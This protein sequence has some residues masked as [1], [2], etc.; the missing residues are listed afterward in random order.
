VSDLILQ[1]WSEHDWYAHR[2]A[3]DEVLAG[4]GTDPVFGSW[5][6]QTG[7]W[8]HFGRPAGWEFLLLAFECEGSIVGFLPAYS[9]WTRRR[10]LALRSVQLLGHHFRDENVLISEYLDVVALPDHALEIARLG[11]D[12]LLEKTRCDEF[13]ACCSLSTGSMR[14]ALLERGRIHGAYCRETDTASAYTIDLSKG[15]VDYLETIGGSMRRSLYLTRRKLEDLG[16]VRFDHAPIEEINETLDTLN[17][18]HA[19]RWGQPVFSGQRLA[20]HRE[21][22]RAMATKRQLVLSRLWLENR[23]VSVLYDVVAGTRQYNLQMGFDQHVGRSMS[24]GLLHIG[25]ALEDAVT[26]QVAKYDLLAGPGK[27]TQYKAKL[28]QEQHILS[29]TQLL[30]AR[31]LAALYRFYDVIIRNQ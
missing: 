7:W 27:R 4:S 20:F 11:L 16:A 22:A 10:G 30:N 8:Q 29:N 2:T 17:R 14:R 25:Y 13:V 21:F 9:A 18:L 19:T 1:Q 23:I 3:W 15:F 5:E 6:W 24:L 12:H 26:R 28:A 31:W